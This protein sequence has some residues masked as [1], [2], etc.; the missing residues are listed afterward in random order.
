MASRF[1]ERARERF[2]YIEGQQQREPLPRAASTT[3]QPGRNQG[4]RNG[5]QRKPRAMRRQRRE[6]ELPQHFEREERQ[7]SRN[8]ETRVS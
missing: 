7:R 1:D 2:R 3:Q 8:G 6:H 5:L 4:E